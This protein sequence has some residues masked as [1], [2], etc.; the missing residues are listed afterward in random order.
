MRR[1]AWVLPAVVVGV[2]AL[3]L[4]TDRTFGYDWPDHLWLVW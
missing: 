4:F 3:P 2:L 1:G